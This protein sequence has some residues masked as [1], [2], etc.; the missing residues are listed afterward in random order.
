MV[1]AHGLPRE[2]EIKVCLRLGGFRYQTAFIQHFIALQNVFF[3][4]VFRFYP[5][6]QM[7]ALEPFLAYFLR[8]RRVC[9]NAQAADDGLMLPTGAT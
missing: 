8:I 1:V 7:N 4:A 9:P 5:P 3:R 6:A 2:R